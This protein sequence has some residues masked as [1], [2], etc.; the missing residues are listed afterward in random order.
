MN[1]RHPQATQIAAVNDTFRHNLGKPGSGGVPGRYVMTRTVGALD[2]WQQLRLFT[3]VVAYDT[4]DVKEDDPYG[5]HDFG[6]VT[7][8]GIRYFWKIDFYANDSCRYGAEDLTAAGVYRV[9]TIMRADD[10]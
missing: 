5:L 4:F 8:E 7:V 1:M 10:Y 3:A 9:L 6:A 2:R